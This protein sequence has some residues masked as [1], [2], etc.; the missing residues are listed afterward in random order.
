MREPPF[1]LPQRHA[2]RHTSAGIDEISDGFGLEQVHPPVR[3]RSP[4]EFAGQCLPCASREQSFHH[5]DRNQTA[6]VNR[7]LEDVLACVAPRAR[8]Q[9][10]ESLVDART[11]RR[12]VH[13]GKT[14]Q[15][16]SERREVDDHLLAN[17]SDVT[18]AY[19]NQ[20]SSATPRRS[21]D[22][23]NR[24]IR[25]GQQAAHGVSGEHEA[26]TRREDADTV[27]ALVFRKAIA[28]LVDGSEGARAYVMKRA[29]VE[30][31]EVSSLCAFKEIERI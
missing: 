6:P 3:D 28:Q 30:G 15:T 31:D 25:Q 13:R 7:Y 27:P 5:Q 16:G 18:P 20:R 17:T 19:S 22:C 2:M 11:R 23:C 4:R 26:L 12:V 29:P 24:V 9:R 21:G 1:Q 14:H 8:E 10:H